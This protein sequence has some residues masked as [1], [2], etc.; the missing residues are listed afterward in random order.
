MTLRALDK[1]RLTRLDEWQA[2]VARVEQEI[3]DYTEAAVDAPSFDRLQFYKGVRVGL[4]RLVE[5]A[6]AVLEPHDG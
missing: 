5:I 6:D 4:N 3:V 2:I 1:A